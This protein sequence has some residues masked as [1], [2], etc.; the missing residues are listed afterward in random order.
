[1]PLIFSFTL[2]ILNLK[3]SNDFHLCFG[4]QRE[5][6]EIIHLTLQ[7]HF[8]LWN[9]NIICIHDNLKLVISLRSYLLSV[10]SPMFLLRHFKK[11]LLANILGKTLLI[12]IKKFA[13]DQMNI[14]LWKWKPK[15]FN[16]FVS[17]KSFRFSDWLNSV[18]SLS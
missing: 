4:K 9:S 7:I 10:A 11:L 15:I 6:A 8:I 5:N 18:T 14:L 1:M 13:F 3:T 17:D 16:D 12:S 2:A